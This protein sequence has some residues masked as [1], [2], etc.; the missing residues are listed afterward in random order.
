MI[1]LFRKNIKIAGKNP[2]SGNT[3]NI[4]SIK[5]NDIDDFRLGKGPFKTIA[6]FEDY[7]KNFSKEE[8]G[9]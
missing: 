3:T 2:G 8:K 7:W 1:F 5:S 4:G 9:R 6:E